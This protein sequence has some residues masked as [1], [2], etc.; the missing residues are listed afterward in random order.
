MVTPACYPP[1]DAG[2]RYSRACPPYTIPYPDRRFHLSSQDARNTTMTEREVDSESS[3]PR[4]R[5]AV[6][7]GRCRKRK[8]R[9]SGDLGNGLPCSNCKNAGHEPCLFLRVSSTETHLRNDGNNFDYNLDAARPFSNQSRVAVS[10]LSSIAEYPTDVT[11]GDVLTSY[12]QSQ[13]SPYGSKGYCSTMSGWTGSYQDDTVD[14]NLSYPYPMLTQEPA[15]M[16]QSYTRYGPGKSIYVEPETPTYSYGNLVHRPAV[17]SESPTGF[18]LAGM[19][20]SLPNATDRVVP[21]DR[22][23]PQVNR[24]LTGSSTFRDGLPTYTSSKTSLASSL[25]EVGYGNLNSSFDPPYCTTNTLTSSGP[26]RSASQHDVAT[27]QSS[28]THTAGSPY[29]SSDHTLRSPEDA[30]SGLSYIY[31]DKLDSSRRES[32]STGGASAGSVLPNGHIYV[33]DSH[34]SHHSSSQTSVASQGST[35]HGATTTSSRGS[36]LNGSSHMHT[37]GHRRS[38]GNLR[39]G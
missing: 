12:R 6:A 31:S 9:C 24:T 1:S 23:L 8:I 27:Y 25:S 26:H 7:C 39:G 3:Q 17:T 11:G 5:I 30:N 14:Y 33:P 20:A 21:S 22:L 4:K 32:Q 15:H 38:A 36:G 37:D 34:H 16:V 18:S 13:Y 29:T 10:H 35:A 19:A 28:G 2:K